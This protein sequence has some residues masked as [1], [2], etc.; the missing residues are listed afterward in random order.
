MYIANISFIKYNNS[1]STN[2]KFYDDSSSRM[3]SVAVI[4]IL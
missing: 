2:Q 1:F 4:I 3:F